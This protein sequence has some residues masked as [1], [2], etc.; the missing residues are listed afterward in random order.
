MTSTIFPLKTKRNVNVPAPRAAAPT[1]LIMT[2]SVPIKT[3]V[4]VELPLYT[5]GDALCT[6]APNSV[7]VKSSTTKVFTGPTFYLDNSLGTKITTFTVTAIPPTGVVTFGL[8][9]NNVQRDITYASAEGS[10]NTRPYGWPGV[11]AL[12]GVTQWGSILTSS[13]TSLRAAFW[14]ANQLTSVPTTLPS[15]VT[16]LSHTFQWAYRFNSKNVSKWNTINVT[17][18][19]FM[20][21]YTS[22]FNQSL[23]TWNVSNVTTMK[24][25]FTEALAFN[26]PLSTWNVTKVTS[27]Q[28]MFFEAVSFNQDISNWNFA[29]SNLNTSTTFGDMFKG[30]CAFSNVNY[31]LIGQNWPP[32]LPSGQYN[33]SFSERNLLSEKVISRTQYATY[34]TKFTDTTAYKYIGNKTVI[35]GTD[36]TIGS[37]SYTNL[38]DSGAGGEIYTPLTTKTRTFFFTGTKTATL[39]TATTESY[40][41]SPSLYVLDQV[42]KSIRLLVDPDPVIYQ[43]KS[44]TVT[45]GVN[46][47]DIYMTPSE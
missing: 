26:Q 21:F 23:K 2:F 8:P 7:T 36:L 25:M 46:S 24:N 4:Y 37:Y 47:Y 34:L 13:L 29:Q 15:N 42:N 5:S 45:D 40:S 28:E 33:I 32:R 10:L 17:D 27:F 35:V 30:A 20:F 6:M 31:G 19:S 18:M 1:A 43:G 11:D 22:T 9:Y 44:I 14:Y 3:V 16:N 41:F 38:Y 12:T 39:F